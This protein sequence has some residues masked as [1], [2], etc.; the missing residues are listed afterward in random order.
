MTERPMNDSFRG[1]PPVNDDGVGLMTP[2][3]KTKLDGLVDVAQIYVHPTTDGNKHLPVI[4]TTNAGKMPVATAV[5]GEWELATPSNA[6]TFT[7]PQL[8]RIAVLITG[9]TEGQVLSVKADGT[10]EW[11]TLT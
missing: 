7:E 6:G 9:G 2:T 5:A 8:A 4:S 1:I 10:L 11:K 3:D